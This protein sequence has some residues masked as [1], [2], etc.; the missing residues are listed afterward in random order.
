MFNKV[1]KIRYLATV[2]T[3]EP[4]LP[5]ADTIGLGYNINGE[6]ARTES[7]LGQCLFD[8]PTGDDRTID[9]EGKVYRYN[10]LMGVNM[11][12]RSDFRQVQGSTIERYREELGQSVGVEGSYKLFS[13]S[14]KAAY[15]SASLS[16]EET[17][18]N[19]VREVHRL[20]QINLP[21]PAQLRN[22][23]KPEAKALIE[24]AD[25]SPSRVFDTLGAYY[26]SEILV[27]GRIDYSAATKTLRTNNTYDVSVTAQASYK[28]LVGEI[29]VETG[30]KLAKDIENFRQVS[31]LTLQTVGGKP[32]LASR[33]FHDDEKNSAFSEWCASLLN[34]AVLMDFTDESLV[35]VWLLASNEKRSS[36]L[37]AAFPL[38]LSSKIHPIPKE[39]RVLALN[40]LPPMICVGT[41]AGSGASQD[42]SVWMPSTDAQNKYTGQFAQ[43]N[44]GASADGRSALLRDVY[45]LGYL[46]APVDYVLVWTDQGSGKSKDFACWRAIPPAG[47]RTLG[48]IMVLGSNGYAIPDN[49]KNNFMCVH[50]SLC[51]DLAESDFDAANGEIWNDVGTHASRDLSLWRITPSQE[52]HS[53]TMGTFLGVNHRG[54]INQDDI[55]RFRGVLAVLME[56]YTKV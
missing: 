20:W 7:T 21:S 15:N 23:L 52:S 6:Y 38:W 32:G 54:R 5:G 4:L 19:T 42:L 9:I 28:A 24:N 36:E 29:K 30:S 55:S 31:E 48:D 45:D 50:E 17:T 53:V 39:Q 11:L 2:G 1:P 37:A 41:D 12:F 40:A 22:Y 43:R 44:H 14:L 10:Q 46:K 33:I 18:Y 13:A 26:L 16:Q 35:P 47:Y 25:V 3:N 34:Y 49:I 8:L 51:R 56:N 27:G